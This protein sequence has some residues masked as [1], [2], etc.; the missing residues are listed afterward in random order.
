[1]ADFGECQDEKI[2]LENSVSSTQAP[3]R[4]NIRLGSSSLY[5]DGNIHSQNSSLKNFHPDFSPIN[6]SQ[7][8]YLYNPPFTIP[9]IEESNPA[10][11]SDLIYEAN[12]PGTPALRDQRHLIIEDVAEESFRHPSDDVRRYPDGSYQRYNYS[13]DRHISDCLS[14][15]NNFPYPPPAAPPSSPSQLYALLLQRN[16]R[17]LGF[18]QVEPSSQEFIPNRAEWIRPNIFQR[19]T[20]QADLH[21]DFRERG[22]LSYNRVFNNVRPRYDLYSHVDQRT[23]SNQNYQRLPYKMVRIK[24]PTD[25][26]DSDSMNGFTEDDEGNHEC[27]DLRHN[28]LSVSDNPSASVGELHHNGTMPVGGMLDPSGMP[29]LGAIYQGEWPMHRALWMSGPSSIGEKDPLD[30][31]GADDTESIMSFSS[32]TAT[33]SSRRTHS[34]QLGTKVEMVYSLLSMLGSCNKDDMSRTLLEMSSNQDSCIAM[35]QSGCLPLLIQLLHG[36][37]RDQVSVAEQRSSE[38]VKW[39]V[40]EARRR[41]SQALH[42]IVHAHPD[43]RRGRREAR[44]LRLLEQI[45]DYSDFL[46]DLGSSNVDFSHNENLDLHPGPAI[47][48]LMKLSFDEEHRHAMCQLGG[49]QAIAELIQADH[50][51]HGNTSDQFCVTVRRYAGMALTNLTFGDGTNKALLCSMKPFMQALVAQLHSPNEDLRQVTASVLRNLSWRADTS[52][53]EILREVGVVTTLMKAAME[54]QKESTLKSILS[55]LWNLSAHCSM[56]K[57]DICEVEGALEFLVSTLTYKSSSNTLSIVENGGGILRNVSSHIAVR[58]DYRATLRQHKCLQTLLS[59]L[60]SPSLTIVSNACGTLWNLSARCAED[61]QALWEMGAVGMLRNLIHSK[62]KMISMGSSAALKNLLAAKPDGMGISLGSHSENGHHV[63]GGSPNMPSLLV[64]KQRALA[65]DLDEDLAETCDNIDSPK[66]SPTPNGDISKKLAYETNGFSCLDRKPQFLS[67]LPGR[68]YHSINGHVGSPVRVP[69]SESKDSLGSTRSEPPHYK[70]QRERF[71]IFVN[72]NRSMPFDGRTVHERPTEWKEKT[73]LPFENNSNVVLQMF[74]HLQSGTNSYES[75]EVKTNGH[76]ELS[77]GEDKPAVR[78]NTLLSPKKN[79]WGLRNNRIAQKRSMHNNLSQHLIH[80]GFNHLDTNGFAS[81]SSNVSDKNVLSS[82]IE[83][84][85]NKRVNSTEKFERSYTHSNSSF[86]QENGI[87]ENEVKEKPRGVVLRHKKPSD[88]M[89][90]S[91]VTVSKEMSDAASGD[92]TSLVVSRCSSLSSLT[93]CFQHSARS[94]WVS[95]VSQRTSAVISP[96]DLP[97]SPGYCTTEERPR[98][99]EFTDKVSDADARGLIRPRPAWPSGSTQPSTDSLPSS[100]KRMSLDSDVFVQSNEAMQPELSTDQSENCDILDSPSSMKTIPSRPQNSP[101]SP[102]KDQSSSQESST[103]L[104]NDDQQEKAGDNDLVAACISLGKPSAVES[105]QQTS[106]THSKGNNLC[107]SLSQIRSGIPIKS[108]LTQ[109]LPSPNNPDATSTNAESHNFN[110]QNEDQSLCD[111]ND[112]LVLESENVNSSPKKEVQRISDFEQNLKKAFESKFLN[113]CKKFPALSHKSSF[114]Q[115]DEKP[116]CSSFSTPS[117]SKFAGRG[118]TSIPQIIRNE[119]TSVDELQTPKQSH[120]KSESSPV[121]RGLPTTSCEQSLS[122]STKF[123]G[124]SSS[125]EENVSEDNILSS[126]PSACDESE[127][128]DSD[129]RLIAANAKA[130]EVVLRNN[131]VRSRKTKANRRSMEI[132]QSSEHSSEDDNRNPF[133]RSSVIIADPSALHILSVPSSENEEKAIE[134]ERMKEKVSMGVIPDLLEGAAYYD[135]LS[136]ESHQQSE[137]GY[138]GKVVLPR[139]MTDSMELRR[140]ALLVAAELEDGIEDCTHSSTS[141]DLE[142]MKPPSCMAEMSMTSSGL[143]DLL[144]NGNGCYI[145]GKRAVDRRRSIKRSKKI[146]SSHR[147]VLKSVR[148]TIANSLESSKHKERYEKPVSSSTSLENISMKSSGTSDLIDNVNPPSIFEDISMTNSCASLNSIS[149]DILESRSQSLADARSS[150]EMFQRF[151]AAAA[152]VQVYSRELSN[153]M[154]SSMKSSCNSDCLDLVK[155]PSI[156]QDIAEVTIEDGTDAVTDPL[157]S[158]FELEEELP[159]DDEPS[160]PSTNTIHS[161]F[162]HSTQRIDDSAENLNSSFDGDSYVD[163]SRISSKGISNFRLEPQNA[164][165][166]LS[167]IPTLL[168]DDEYSSGF[169]SNITTDE[170]CSMEKDE[171]DSSPPPAIRK[172]PRI[173]KPINRETVRQMQ[174]KKS[175]EKAAKSVRGRA[176][177][178]RNLLQQV[179]SSRIVNANKTSVNKGAPTVSGVRM[180]RTQALRASQNKQSSTGRASPRSFLSKPPSATSRSANRTVRQ[181]TAKANVSSSKTDDEKMEIS[182]PQPPVKQNTFIKDEVTSKVPASAASGV[183]SNQPV[184]CDERNNNEQSSCEKILS[185]GSGFNDKRLPPTS[186]DS[187]STS[188]GLQRKL[189]VPIQRRSNEKGR[190]P[191]SPSYQGISFLEK[192]SSKVP[193]KRSPGSSSSVGRGTVPVSGRTTS[194]NSLS[195]MSSNSFSTKKSNSQKEVPSKI[196]SIWKRSESSSSSSNSPGTDASGGERSHLSGARSKPNTASKTPTARSTSI[197]S[198]STKT[199][200]SRSSTYEKIDKISSNSNSKP[201]VNTRYSAPPRCKPST[202]TTRN[203]QK[204][205]PVPGK[206]TGGARIVKPVTPRP[207]PNAITSRTLRQSS[208]FT[209]SYAAS[210]S[211]PACI[212]SGKT[213]GN[214]QTSKVSIPLVTAPFAYNESS[215]SISSK[216]DSNG[217]H[218]ANDLFHNVHHSSTVFNNFDKNDS[219]SDDNNLAET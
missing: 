216:N 175:A 8:H 48:A 104:E 53:K 207:K 149:S 89:S 31:F 16:I 45:R 81:D 191:T 168:T 126:S 116:S 35:R 6:V 200:L 58:E 139:N 24:N 141:F 54:A 51:V 180:T 10:D 194:S 159:H 18:T 193:E 178:S 95:D 60:K 117:Y 78:P 218:H 187:A 65:A 97:D 199:T 122:P 128:I 214:S 111:D 152:M 134:D 129:D 217:I 170:H 136:S 1:M 164:T 144:S 209:P 98:I 202:Y 112:N 72:N 153:I 165:K 135:G 169:F 158:D 206:P 124:H 208:T 210:S 29:T 119:N 17:P 171:N 114:E 109:S 100:V 96:T 66:T 176:S 195:S 110:I 167:G 77:D 37:E 5:R 120:F 145:N 14:R 11:S 57:A 133:N 88:C 182:R 44:V 90:T 125:T 70:A 99:S 157:V 212:T 184:L 201:K 52:S 188:T 179:T 211:P 154:T 46:R 150:S 102:E 36:S 189:S 155:P 118:K 80:N 71:K 105:P 137:T 40:R 68:M 84:P 25:D 34:H 181:P 177:G 15:E 162:L 93:S 148:Q 132:R 27:H 197:N 142:N 186:L 49:L 26:K 156:F 42:N 151:N 76:A 101:I 47:A 87:H 39:A 121:C 63:N 38:N 103:S 59:H 56:N 163:K 33:M 196:S 7:E 9:L 79:A 85:G 43:D 172:G 131:R 73:N 50:E 28:T 19:P 190:I 30:G 143:S 64:R 82:I 20:Q 23:F 215:D 94:S 146:S 86:I 91:A 21:H 123:L 127:G 115:S 174:E 32:S 61:Q 12:R 185:S 13:Q 198:E 106:R 204:A 192:G 161:P 108:R 107:S 183:S 219:E 67:Y 2:D 74:R 83:F 205:P 130:S 138:V 62:H 4:P 55:A 3:K 92:P 75:P 140:G 22:R 166:A 173:V 147:F 113:V 203:T 69:R 213:Y 160:I 41:A